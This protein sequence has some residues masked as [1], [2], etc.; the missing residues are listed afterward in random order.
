M[1]FSSYLI[2]IHNMCITCSIELLP[3]NPFWVWRTP[4]LAS[5]HSS[6]SLTASLTTSLF[7]L[8]SS[9]FP[10]ENW[11]VMIWCESKFFVFSCDK[12]EKIYFSSAVRPAANWEI[13][14]TINFCTKH[15]VHI[16]SQ[17]TKSVIFL[18]DF[19]R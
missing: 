10:L 16:L 3:R 7:R 13:Q 6:V 17:T 2:L 12:K 9:L 11:Y 4:S 15:L 14:L 18:L 8:T 1:L 5:I 19:H